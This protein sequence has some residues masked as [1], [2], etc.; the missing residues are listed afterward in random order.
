MASPNYTNG[1]SDEIRNDL[2]FTSTLMASLDPSASDYLEQKAA[3]AKDQAELESQLKQQETTGTHDHKETM[4]ECL[5]N[6][7]RSEIIPNSIAAQ[8]TQR[9]ISHMANSKSN[10]GFVHYANG[11]S[12]GV[13][14]VPAPDTATGRKPRA[15]SGEPL[16]NIESFDTTNLS[17]RGQSQRDISGRTS[18][19]YVSSPD[20]TSVASSPSLQVLQPNSRKRPRESPTLPQSIGY[21]MK[22]SRTTPS[23]AMTRS[24][25][26][27]STTSSSFPQDETLFRLL[28]GNPNEDIRDLRKEQKEVEKVL[29]RRR[30]QE[31][32]DEEIARQLQ[33][34]WEQETSARPSSVASNTSF[35]PPAS[36]STPS[37]LSIHGP[38]GRFRRPD[39]PSH[40]GTPPATYGRGVKTE[41]LSRILPHS[42]SGKGE[43]NLH[44][45]TS[46]QSRLSNF[47]DLGSDE[48]EDQ[49]N[50][51]SS[52]LIEIN[53]ASFQNS[54]RRLPWQSQ[55]FAQ[56]IQDQV[57]GNKINKNV[58]EEADQRTSRLPGQVSYAANPYASQEGGIG[59]YGRVPPSNADWSGVMN[60]HSWIDA[61]GHVRAG[62]ANA[63]RN[64]Y[65]GA[66]SLLDEQI[67]SMPGGL[68]GFGAPGYG[69]GMLAASGNPQVLGST[70]GYSPPGTALA[71]NTYS[72][73]AADLMDGR[74]PDV[75]F[76]SERYR[77]RIYD[78]VADP[79]A[80]REEI[81]NLLENIR[82]DQDLAPEDRE[83]TPEAMA[84]ALMEHQKLGLTWMKNMEEGSNRGGILA[85]D[86]GL[87]K[88]IQALALMV[89][90][91]STDP[92]RKTTLIVAPVAL[93]KQWERE[94]QIKIKPVP[95]YRLS[96][97]IHHGSKRRK[98]WED[99]KTYDVVLT[100]FGT[101]AT[102]YN[103]ME[104]I[105]MA[106]KDT[107]NWR[108]S[109]D[110]D[111]LP[112]LGE[113]SQWYRVIIDE[114]QCIKNK[115]TKAAKAAYR[116]RAL[117][118]FCMSGTPMMNNVKELF[119]LIHFLR[120]K[121]YNEQ[122]RFN[123]D[124]DRPLKG[125]SQ[126]GKDQAMRKLQAL[127]KAILLRRT[128]KSQIDGRPIL[129]LP[130]RITKAQHADFSPDEC[131]FYKALETQSQ[132]QFNRY[133]KANTVG[134]NYSNVLVLLLRL[135]QA[136]CHPHLIK[137]FGISRDG[138]AD[139]SAKDLINVAKMLAPEVVKRIK[140]AG[141]I[142]CPICMDSAENATIFI[143][144][145]HSTCSECFVRISDPTQAIAEG[146]ASERDNIKCPNCRG[147][148]VRNQVTDFESF[149]NVHMPELN[150]DAFASVA[151][152][153]AEAT[154][155][156]TD[157][158]DEDDN[159]DDDDLKG[160]IVKDGVDDDEETE[161]ETEFSAGYRHGND[162][163]EKAACA[164][165]KNTKRSRRRAKGK[166]KA[167]KPIRKTLAQLKAESHRNVKARRKYLKKLAHDWESSAKIS[168][169]MEILEAVQNRKEGEK[170]IIFSQFTSLL[171]LLEIPIV[172]ND[173]GYRRYD[174]SM[175][176]T[177]RNDAVIT[178]TDT[179]ECKIM[180]VSL[181]AGNAGLNL[182]AASQVII[183]DPFWNPYIE[184]QAIDRAHRIGQQRPV[185]VHRVLVAN[186]VEDRIL[187]LQEKKRDLIEGA[188]DEKASQNI[189][190]LGTR[191]LA[192]LFGVPA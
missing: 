153:E 97:C 2:D 57:F 74:A 6:Q 184:E 68:R 179:P 46:K 27:S 3:L 185:Q 131:A 91:R 102:E 43:T 73:L 181:K 162:P 154:E 186:T 172:R 173:W 166:S 87:G 37:S 15:M 25:T 79:T 14:N 70:P 109:S 170:T 157:S 18:S 39:P 81:K 69:D 96:C 146:D 112:L 132:L 99:L 65:N 137:D 177:A 123:R 9:P 95:P 119:S 180:L 139:M 111:R 90:R 190:R 56:P 38:S 48:S 121:P 101:L 55:Q 84:K 80:T 19:S 54:G 59:V 107:P 158:D 171:D 13:E 93:M 34:E 53:S 147:K 176:A 151:T 47:I 128:K 183:L 82:P 58:W 50:S 104:G 144:C 44:P 86:M 41:P 72:N 21:G 140:E 76:M 187:A 108:P 118:R 98:R 141:P 110:K 142:E 188:L 163:F 66:Y 89:S 63:A 133:L 189:G 192:F 106:K 24:T 161:S 62:L 167:D 150:T 51:S 31:S 149:K 159:N 20:P 49:G 28:G 135:R 127:L 103:R 124:F 182:T 61:A 77:N 174:G 113:T 156:E 23:P 92:D 33:V 30:E 67:G 165:V 35:A 40:Y 12:S 4:A 117:S 32:H 7:S 120:I 160:F 191:E 164:T 148:I 22:S 85:D 94:I 52:D 16:W 75:S 10:S 168:K 83:G 115:D 45:G 29:Q 143:P 114:A 78:M 64:V 138:P 88:T 125:Q 155:S 152:E 5:R 129:E 11:N 1:T 71:Q 175:S 178:F 26:P 169:T 136:C 105:E 145:G 100:T 8:Q 116:L 122:E 126:S 130:E 60:P 17:L 134:R 36:I 42:P